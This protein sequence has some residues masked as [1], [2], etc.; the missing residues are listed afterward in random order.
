VPMPS[1]SHL[2]RLDHVHL[3]VSIPQQTTI[4]RL[5]QSLKGRTAHH[6]LAEFPH[7]K[8]QFRG[9]ASIPAS[10]MVNPSTA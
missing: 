6:L 7:L 1:A 8:K 3:L 2:V 5:M 4:S 10:I 9:P